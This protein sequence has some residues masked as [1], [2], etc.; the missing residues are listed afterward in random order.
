MSQ[1]LHGVHRWADK[2]KT[3]SLQPHQLE[4]IRTASLQHKVYTAGEG[5]MFGVSD[6]SYIQHINTVSLATGRTFGLQ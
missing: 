5:F 3:S 4:G 1:S 6:F 2:P